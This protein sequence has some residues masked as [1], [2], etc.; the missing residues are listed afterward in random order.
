[1]NTR[2][3]FI[4]TEVNSLPGSEFPGPPGVPIFVECYVAEDRID[5]ALCKVERAL[6]VEHYHLNDV[7]RC[8]RFDLEEWNFDDYP[9]DSDARVL[10]ERV[11]VSGQVEFG[12]FVFGEST[13]RRA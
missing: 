2:V 6:A 12:P 4:M 5:E 8:V 10:C 13:E 9:A 1:M 7:S 3:W 11:A